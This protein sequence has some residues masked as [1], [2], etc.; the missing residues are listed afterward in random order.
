MSQMGPDSEPLSVRRKVAVFNGP[1]VATES[2]A[3]VDACPYETIL[4]EPTSVKVE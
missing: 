3:R 4:S 2:K 1:K